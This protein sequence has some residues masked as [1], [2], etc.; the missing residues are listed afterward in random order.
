LE[1]VKV[2]LSQEAQAEFE[3][4]LGHKIFGGLAKRY[5]KELNDFPPENWGDIH[6]KEGESLFKS[7]NHVIFDI[8]GKIILGKDGLA[9]TVKIV[10]FRL[11]TKA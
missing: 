3:A 1:K 7:D 5:L 10:R 4:L 2:L 8:Q 9:E 6:H 11:R